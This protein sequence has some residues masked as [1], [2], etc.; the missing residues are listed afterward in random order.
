M[1][2]GAYGGGS[3]GGRASQR[4]MEVKLGCEDRNSAT[5]TGLDHMSMGERV[6]G[7]FGQEKRC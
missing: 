2:A 5:R 6:V 1:G 4:G 3:G 7:L